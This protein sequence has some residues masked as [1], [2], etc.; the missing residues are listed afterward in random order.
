MTACSQNSAPSVR[1]GTA[2]FHCSALPP[3]AHPHPPRRR[4]RRR[5]AC[6]LRRRARGIGGA[7][8]RY[9]NDPRTFGHREEITRRKRATGARA[10]GSAGAWRR[11]GRAAT[12]R[13]RGNPGR[14]GAPRPPASRGEMRVM[15][16]RAR[17]L[18][19]NGASPPTGPR[20]PCV[21]GTNVALQASN[22][23]KEEAFC[24]WSGKHSAC[25]W[26]CLPSLSRNP[27]RPS[28]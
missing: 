20:Q 7:I 2:D 26:L 12:S 23:A 14:P 22:L 6:G 27:L 9:G 18:V 11:S 15:A 28:P 25:S 21:P 8:A 5:A 19:K 4:S 1:S 13:F 17:G 3:A 24:P 16:K 10:H